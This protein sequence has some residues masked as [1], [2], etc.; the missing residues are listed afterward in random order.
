LLEQ[1]GTTSEVSF[2]SR[3][4]VPGLARS[5]KFR[6]LLVGVANT[7]FG[8]LL[9]AGLLLAVGEKS[10]V[11]TGVISHLVATTLSFGLNRTYVFGSEGRILF[12]YLRFQMIYTLILAI[13]LALLIAFVEFLGWPVL[14]AQ[15]V[16]LCFVA[17]AS[18]LGHKYFSFRRKGNSGSSE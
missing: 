8:Y 7:V 16:C 1:F 11:L 4:E 15:A 6:F 2:L 5:Q 9:F 18:Y 10:Y 17:V 3:F 13:N 14:V 12:D